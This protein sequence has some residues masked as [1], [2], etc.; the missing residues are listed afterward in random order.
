VT[1]YKHLCL[2]SSILVLTSSSLLSCATSLA[3]T[4]EDERQRIEGSLPTLKRARPSLHK[5]PAEPRQKGEQGLR[6]NEDDV[7]KVET[8]LVVC[9]V[10]VLDKQGKTVPGLTQ[11]D[12][13]VTENDKPQQIGSFSLGDNTAVPR[14]IVLIM[15]YSVSMT[16]YIQMSVD[17]AK[18]LVDKLGPK[19]TMAIVAD[20][21]SLLA[22]FT[23]DKAE[24]K[25]KLELSKE[26][27][28]ETDRSWP[29]GHSLQ[30][31]ALLATL[32]EMFD[33][34]DVRPIIIFQ[35]DGDELEIMQPVVDASHAAI[36]RKFSLKDVYS[37]AEKSRATIYSVIPGSRLID[38]SE[39]GQWKLARSQVREIRAR[40][41]HGKGLGKGWQDKYAARF[42]MW[43]ESRRKEQLAVAGVAELTG[44]LTESLEDPAQAEEIYARILA[45]INH[46][47][48]ITY[49]PTNKE[50]DGKRR[51][52]R[53]EVRGHPEFTVW[54][55]KSYHAPRPEN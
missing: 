22:D 38:L 27:A 35:T 14:S 2:A 3:Q 9:D 7:V 36:A 25:E 10:L 21:L 54:G 39:E 5:G 51:T 42:K 8:S 29:S 15:D 45:S 12:F 1:G 41:P 47:Y 44:G 23:G 17:A 33:A 13:L 20:D 28:N 46:R 6:A 19:D 34:E 24:L 48:V 18:V 32:R 16:S 26:R 4:P 37:E 40:N 30:F 55:R 31:S 50:H 52:V 43:I 11:H 53:I 49:Y